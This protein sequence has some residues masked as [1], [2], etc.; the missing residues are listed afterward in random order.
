MDLHKLASRVTEIAQNVDLAYPWVSNDL[1]EL[2][3]KASEIHGL[4]HPKG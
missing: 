4:F 2:S 3:K 1:M